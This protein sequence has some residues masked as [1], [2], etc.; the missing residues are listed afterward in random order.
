MFRSLGRDP[1]GDYPDVFLVS[2]SVD[3]T[4]VYVI[5]VV[6]TQGSEEVRS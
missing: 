5:S 4:G 3:T 2:E 6:F 1:G